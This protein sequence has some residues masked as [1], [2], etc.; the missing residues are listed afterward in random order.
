M[1]LKMRRHAHCE[2]SKAYATVVLESSLKAKAER[3]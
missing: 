2:Q 1:H 3:Q